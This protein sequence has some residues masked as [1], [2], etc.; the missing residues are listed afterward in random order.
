MDVERVRIVPNILELQRDERQCPTSARRNNQP[1]DHTHRG[2]LE[3][4]RLEIPKHHRNVFAYARVPD[5][6]VLV[7][8]SS[9]AEHGPM[10]FVSRHRDGHYRGIPDG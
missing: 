10:G 7:E 3:T 4:W 6:G 9:R 1:D 2:N 8:C 5:A